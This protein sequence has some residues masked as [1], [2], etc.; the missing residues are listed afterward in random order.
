MRLED[1]ERFGNHTVGQGAIR[2]HFLSN[3]S[4]YA[5]IG[6]AFRAPSLNEMYSQWGGNE[7]LTPEE[8]TSYEIGLDYDIT[9][10]ISTNLSVYDT[11]IE[12]LIA[13]IAGKNTNITKAKFTG[14]ELGLKWQQDD[15]FI[16][17]QYAYVKTENKATGLEIAYRPK[18]TVTLTT[19]LEN[20]TYGVNVSAIARSNSNASNTANP[21]KIPGY[22]TVDFNAFWNINPNV[23]LFTNI[24]NIGDVQYKEVYKDADSWSN[25]PED[26][27]INGGR[28]ASTGVTFR[29]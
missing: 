19:G 18:N 23:K 9:P 25:S 8:S 10:N 16:S 24:Q 12:N 28:F 1:N 11:N 7:N 17:T 14:G 21:V 13:P 15:Y 4:V 2:Y 29:Y 6:T 22:A 20:A 26:W 3:A 27:Y 5:N